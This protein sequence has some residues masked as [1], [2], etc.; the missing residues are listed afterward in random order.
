MWHAAWA[1]GQRRG[2]EDQLVTERRLPVRFLGGRLYLLPS[3]LHGVSIF[4]ILP[5]HIIAT[6]RR[7]GAN[8]PSA[9]ICWS[10]YQARP[11]Q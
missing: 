3:R 4:W 10:Q 9:L 2:L 7:P 6:Q 8:S 5:A 11:A 1:A